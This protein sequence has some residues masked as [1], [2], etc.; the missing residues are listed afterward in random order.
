MEIERRP[1]RSSL[2]AVGIL[3]GIC[4][5]PYTYQTAWQKESFLIVVP[6]PVNMFDISDTDN[7]RTASGRGFGLALAWILSISCRARRAPPSR[8]RDTPPRTC[9]TPPSCSPGT[10][11]SF[12]CKG[13]QYS[14]SRGPFRAF[15]IKPKQARINYR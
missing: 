14:R 1:L 9:R 3:R 5:K 11:G 13:R 15:F 7:L 4:A 10:A 6:L 8:C 2:L 12:A